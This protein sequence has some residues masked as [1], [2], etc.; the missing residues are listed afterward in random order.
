M[1]ATER[2]HHVY[3]TPYGL[4]T[5]SASGPEICGVMLGAQGAGAA[6]PSEA[7]NACA[8]Q[9]LEYFAGKR[10]V[11]TVPLLME[12]TDFQRKVWE[13]ICGIPYGQTRTATEIAE[14]IGKPHANRAVGQAVRANPLAVLVPAHRVIAASGRVEPADQGAQLRAAFRKLEQ[15]FSAR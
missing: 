5:I 4:M 1:S 11:F 9:L 6:R 10:A 13:A 2:N 15:G 7:T 3:R 12:G 8:T 14:L